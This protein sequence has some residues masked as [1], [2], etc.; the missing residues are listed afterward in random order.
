MGYVLTPSRPDNLHYW[1]EHVGK[2]ST[3][4]KML[5]GKSA[6]SYVEDLVISYLDSGDL[7]HVKDAVGIVTD[8]QTAI[9]QCDDEILQLD[10]FG[11]KWEKATDITLLVQTLVRWLEEVLRSS[12][13]GHDNLVYAHQHHL[14]MYQV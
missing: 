7:S 5:I 14:L 8:L 12:I 4:C 9:S 13:I 6:S 11:D 2:L 3:K 1:L 10:G